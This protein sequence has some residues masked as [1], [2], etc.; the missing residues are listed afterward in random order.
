MIGI[1]VIG[2]LI[3]VL[4]PVGEGGGIN[5]NIRLVFGLCVAI[6][7]I[8]PIVDIVDGVYELDIGSIVE[9]PEQESEKYDDIFDMSYTSAEVE[10]LKRG[11]KQMLSDRFGI[12]E[13]ECSVSVKLYEKAG[14]EKE[15]ERMYITLSGAAILKN[16]EEIENYLSHIFNCEIIT[17]IE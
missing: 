9:M 2:S 1:S 11:V 13:H 7:C 4:A 10:E 8:K 14:G 15:L 16:T 5:K 12:E 17:I 3:S 6:V